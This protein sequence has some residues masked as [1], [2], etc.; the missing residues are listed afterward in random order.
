MKPLKCRSWSGRNWSLTP[1]AVIISTFAAL[2]LL[3]QESGWAA[4]VVT[5]CSE[6]SLRTAM[7]GGGTV[8]FACDGTITLGSTI[9]IS[10][11]TIL[12]GTGH[13]QGEFTKQPKSLI[14]RV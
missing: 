11:N 2:C 4:G 6:A 9:T 12:D 1:P 14:C 3:M 7:A 13:Q 5:S 8:T 10:V